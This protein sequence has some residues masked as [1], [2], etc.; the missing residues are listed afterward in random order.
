M[1]SG[2]ETRGQGFRK[3]SGAA[4]KGADCELNESKPNATRHGLAANDGEGLRENERSNV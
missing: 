1:R 3:D 4:H 2:A